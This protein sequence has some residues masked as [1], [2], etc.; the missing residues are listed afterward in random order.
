MPTKFKREVTMPEFEKRE[1]KSAWENA[2]YLKHMF[3]S[4]MKSMKEE[5]WENKFALH[6]Q[7]PKILEEPH[8]D[9]VS[10][11]KMVIK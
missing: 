9:T 8:V 1:V 11:N 7:Y 4:K 6:D 5:K 10:T 2:K 3:K